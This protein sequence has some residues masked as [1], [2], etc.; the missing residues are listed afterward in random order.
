MTSRVIKSQYF[1]DDIRFNGD[2]SGSPVSTGQTYQVTDRRND[3]FPLR[4]ATSVCQGSRP[5]DGERR[6]DR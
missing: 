1:I 6:Y 3:D 5:T 4:D 2:N